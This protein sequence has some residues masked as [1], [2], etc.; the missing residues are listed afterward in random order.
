MV[1]LL[2]LLRRPASSWPRPASSLTSRWKE[3]LARL[4][5]ALEHA[6]DPAPDSSSS[7]WQSSEDAAPSLDIN[8]RDSDYLNLINSLIMPAS[9]EFVAADKSKYLFGLCYKIFN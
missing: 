7:C 3:T 1:D 2:L 5:P 6:P 8:S 9:L 4:D